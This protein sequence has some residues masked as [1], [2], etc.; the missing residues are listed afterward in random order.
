MWLLGSVSYFTSLIS[1]RVTIRRAYTTDA[2]RLTKVNKILRHYAESCSFLH[3]YVKYINLR[4][5]TGTLSNH[6]IVRQLQLFK[7]KKICAA[8]LMSCM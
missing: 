2:E 8:C 1:N 7:C 4:L 3:V 6:F 5:F